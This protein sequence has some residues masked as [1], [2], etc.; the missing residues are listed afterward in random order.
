MIEFPVKITEL[1]VGKVRYV[2]RV[3]AA[4]VII[5]G[6]GKKSRKG[7]A[8]HMTGKIGKHPLH[9]IIDDSLDAHRIIRILDVIV[10][11]FLVEGVLGEKRV[12]HCIAIDIN[13]VVV[14]LV[15]LGGNRIDSLVGIGQSVEKGLKRT[16][17]KLLER[18]L[19]RE[20][21]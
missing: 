12:E 15:H 14:V 20:L 10:P 18:V 3:T 9:F 4:F 7:S 1:L 16:F 21:F 8:S 13:Q 2:L 11:P 17:E 5:G 6:V 19:E